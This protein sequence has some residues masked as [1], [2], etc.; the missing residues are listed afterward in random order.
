MAALRDLDELRG[1]AKKAAQQAYAPYSL[2]RV[3]AALSSAA[4]C[5]YTG[6]NVENGALP[7]GGCAERA[8]IATAV[9]AEGAA[10]RLAAIAVAAFATDGAQLP[11][12]PCG[13]CRQALVEFGA[14][15]AVTFR[16]PDGSW[17]EVLAGDL[18]PWRFVMPNR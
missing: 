5:V 16:Q 3:G 12:S 11:V 1:L 13:A 14:E 8:A 17:I 15:A 7:I 6:C 9:Q 4:G 2:L 10:F 18:L